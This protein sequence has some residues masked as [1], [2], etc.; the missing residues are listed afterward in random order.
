MYRR[1]PFKVIV[2]LLTA[3]S[4]L[5]TTIAPDLAWAL[6]TGN[7]LP[8]SGLS[9]GSGPGQGIVKELDVDSFSLPPYL[10]YARDSFKGSSPIVIHI[11][12][13]HCNYNAQKSIYNIIDYLN[14]TY[15]INTI[16]P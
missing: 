7:T 13:A 2:T 14:R 11:Q 3:W 9:S 12:D 15:G 5:F 1:G 16:N 4:F 6:K 8:A 10:G